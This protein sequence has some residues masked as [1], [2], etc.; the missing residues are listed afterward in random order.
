MQLHLTLVIYASLQKGEADWIG[1]TLYEA[2]CKQADLEEEQHEAS[3]RPLKEVYM[4][5]LLYDIRRKNHHY[6]FVWQTVILSGCYCAHAP[7]HP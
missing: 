4:E 5:K 7:K 1:L 2:E 3:I 6:D